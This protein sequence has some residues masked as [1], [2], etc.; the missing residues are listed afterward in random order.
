[1]S[2][3]YLYI[4]EQAEKIAITAVELVRQHGPEKAQRAIDRMV[5]DEAVVVAGEIQKVVEK[6]IAD[7]LSALKRKERVG[8]N[9]S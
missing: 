4:H 8:G 7:C 3:R 9:L 1:M 2:T 5:A 6:R